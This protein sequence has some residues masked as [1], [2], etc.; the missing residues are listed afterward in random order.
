MSFLFG[1]LTQQFVS[2]GSAEAQYFQ[3]V[4]NITALQELEVAAADFRSAAA[5]DASYLVYIGTSPLI[6]F[7]YLL[8]L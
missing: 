1:N 3:D 8:T 2:F 7:I 6:A 5:L 4:N